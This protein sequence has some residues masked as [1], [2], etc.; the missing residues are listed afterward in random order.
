MYANIPHDRSQNRGEHHMQA[1]WLGWAGVEIESESE[2]VVIDPLQ[3]AGAVFAPLGEEAATLARPDVV[4]ARGGA[5]AGLVTH[6]HRDHTDAAALTAA[7]APGAAVHEPAGSTVSGPADLSL[8]MAVHELGEAGLQ[9]VPLAPGEQ[10]A[11]GPFTITALPSVDGLGDPQV[12]WA[13]EAEGK[14]VLHLGDTRFHS[15]WWRMASLHGP[16]DAVFAPINGAVVEF[17][18]L[19]PAS[20]LPAVMEPEEA[21]LAGELLGATTVV[22]I[23]FGGYDNRWYRPVDEPLA[24]FERSMADRPCAAHALE[25]GESLIV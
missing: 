23:H 16:F 14:R 3:D 1:R 19:V 13:V 12:A 17:P 24:R 6:L 22:P 9:R 5:L 4:A 18:H 7:L 2:T 10:V 20:P 11:A 8:A 21:A 25:L 15:Y